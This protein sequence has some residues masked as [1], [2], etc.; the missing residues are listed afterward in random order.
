[1]VGFYL[2]VIFFDPQRCDGIKSGPNIQEGTKITPASARNKN[3][4]NECVL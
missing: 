2:H 3:Y 4:S 1:M